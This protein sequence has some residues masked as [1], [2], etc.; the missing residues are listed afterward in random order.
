MHDR[1]EPHQ[2]I[3]YTLVGMNMYQDLRIELGKMER[4]HHEFHKCIHCNK[5]HKCPN[6]D[7]CLYIVDNKCLNCT[8]EIICDDHSTLPVF[9]KDFYDCWTKHTHIYFRS[10]GL[11]VIGAQ[12]HRGALTS[13]D[14]NRIT[15]EARKINDAKYTDYTKQPSPGR[16][17]LFFNAGYLW[18]DKHKKLPM[19]KYAFGIVSNVLP[20]PPALMVYCIGKLR[21]CGIIFRDALNTIAFNYYYKGSAGIG[22]HLDARSK[23]D[24][25]FPVLII[26]L[27]S[28][29]ILRYATQRFRK[30]ALFGIAMMVGDVYSMQEFQ[31]GTD[32]ISHCLCGVELN[33]DCASLMLRRVYPFLI[34][35]SKQASGK[36]GF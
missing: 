13:I 15:R 14:M 33:D 35:M 25:E 19:F 28:P 6:C 18:S 20:I 5:C 16:N 26:R 3:E 8:S 22:S 7:H 34:K 32:W 1:D 36:L 2:F 4:L 10:Q 31:M 9:D 17:K 12:I 24:V 21:Q 23:F 30:N 29:T 11:I 27:L